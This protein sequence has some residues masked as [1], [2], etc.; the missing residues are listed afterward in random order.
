MA[1][2]G[3]LFVSAAGWLN[4]S[5]FQPGLRTPAPANSWCLPAMRGGTDK[6]AADERSAQVAR[7]PVLACDA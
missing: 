4:P 7:E 3:L 2:A 6:T 1:L 5:I